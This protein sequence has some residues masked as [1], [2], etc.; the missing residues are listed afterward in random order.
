MTG[1][2]T[3]AP[4]VWRRLNRFPE[5]PWK[6]GAEMLGHVENVPIFLAALAGEKSVDNPFISAAAE[7][8]CCA[9]C[10]AGIGNE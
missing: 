6:H 9:A 2:N 3:T 7:Q 5:R 1:N 10:Q 8:H 4:L